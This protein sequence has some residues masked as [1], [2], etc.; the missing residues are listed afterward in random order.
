MLPPNAEAVDW[1]KKFWTSAKSQQPPSQSPV[2]LQSSQQQQWWG[3]LVSQGAQESKGCGF[4]PRSVVKKT[5][6]VI[7]PAGDSWRA[8]K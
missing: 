1:L 8:E 5:N 4:L 2:E 7:V 6:V 3:N